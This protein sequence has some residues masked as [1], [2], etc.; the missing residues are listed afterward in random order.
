MTAKRSCFL[1]FWLPGTYYSP[2]PS[3][4]NLVIVPLRYRTLSL[5]FPS[6]AITISSFTPDQST[7][8]VHLQNALSADLT[9]VFK[10]F[11]VVR[12][13]SISLFLWCFAYGL[14]Y[15]LVVNPWSAIWM[16]I[17]M[18]LW[19]ILCRI[20]MNQLGKGVA[21]YEDYFKARLALLTGSLLR[22]DIVVSVGTG[23]HWLEVGAA[24]DI[25]AVELAIVPNK[26]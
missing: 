21:D 14:F 8:A 23:M 19:A 4:S 9:T 24:N 20:V 18:F 12:L 26:D 7:A 6:L 3:T 11:L 15:S 10:H 22:S 16:V 5:S 13:L 1:C 17:I 2:P 25:T